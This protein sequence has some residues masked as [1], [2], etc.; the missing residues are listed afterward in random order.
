LKIKLV[1][2]RRWR[3][4]ERERRNKQKK[5]TKIEKSQAHKSNYYSYENANY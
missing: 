4:G 3:E 2:D 5:Q 1:K